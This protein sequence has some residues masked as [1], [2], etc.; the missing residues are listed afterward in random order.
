VTDAVAFSLARPDEY[1]CQE[2]QALQSIAE[3]VLDSISLSWSSIALGRRP[4][5][6]ATLRQPS[7]SLRKATQRT[8]GAM[9]SEALQSLNSS[10][11]IRLRAG[12][13]LHTLRIKTRIA[14]FHRGP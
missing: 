4:Q 3:S 7:R 2:Y 6:Q 11:R 13:Y 9:A 1:A 10:R 14:F 5:V 12:Q 8:S